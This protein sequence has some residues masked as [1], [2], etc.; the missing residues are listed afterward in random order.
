MKRRTLAM[1][2]LIFAS[3]LIISVV[4][5]QSALVPTVPLDHGSP[6]IES[7]DS[8]GN[9]TD[10][11]DLGASLYIKGN[12][13]EPG[14]IYYVYIVEDYD[15]WSL[16]ETHISDL[17]VVEGPIAVNVDSAG[18]I[19]S[20]PTLIWDFIEFGEYDIWADSQTDGEI[21]FFDECDALDDLDVDN[22]G[23][24]IIPEMSTII[25]PIIATCLIVLIIRQMMMRKRQ[26]I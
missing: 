21:G 26:A 8:A 11:F 15:S 2:T 5:I 1:V 17:F 13:L 3:A 23:F 22:A 16:S 18:N 7:C 9:V 20:Q 25:F 14:G 19:E 12:D 6:L 24:S 10:L 4:A